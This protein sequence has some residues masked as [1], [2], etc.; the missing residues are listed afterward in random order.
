[1]VPGV[2]VAGVT[3][4]VSGVSVFVNSY[5]VKTFASPAVYTTAKN[6]VAAAVLVLAAALGAR[7]R[8]GRSAVNF[9][10]AP[11][12]QDP[13]RGALH[14]LGLAYVGVVGGG[15][16]FVLFFDG[17]A[18]SQPASAAFWR[19]TMVVWVALLAVFV[20]RDRLRWWNLLAIALLVAG[21]VTVTGGVGRL[22]A[23]RGELDV[24]ASSVLW[25]VEIVV[26]KRL[27]RGIAPARLSVIRMGG[28]AV[29]LVAYLAT[30]GSLGTLLALN[31]AQAGW[32]AL[33]GALLGVYVATWFTALARARALD[34]T[35]VLVGS[36]V[37]TWL[38]QWVAGSASAAPASLGLALIA[39]GVALVAVAAVRPRGLERVRA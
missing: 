14:W 28:G 10:V 12:P 31:W 23:S 25:A 34:V 2:A 36:A 39:V 5:G 3:A 30:Q 32:I 13:R 9:V 16:A 21:E 24:L 19:D 4:L 26:A 37:V 8:A 33:T 15:L 27:L 6:L 1:M 7:S 17:L 20:L 18:L 11:V 35:S 29:A 38:L 22:A